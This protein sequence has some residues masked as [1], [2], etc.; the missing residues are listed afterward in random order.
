MRLQPRAILCTA[1]HVHHHHILTLPSCMRHL[2]WGA[3]SCIHYASFIAPHLIISATPH[4][5]TNDMHTSCFRATHHAH[6]HLALYS[7]AYKTQRATCYLISTHQ[8][9]HDTSKH[10]ATYAPYLCHSQVQR[11]MHHISHIMLHYL[12]S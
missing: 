8:L 5:H 11:P 1:H 6:F 10:M 9:L 3:I 4:E 7:L 12:C 2:E